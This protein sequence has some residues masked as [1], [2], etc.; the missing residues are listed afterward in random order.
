MTIAANVSV[1]IPI[2]G[3]RREAAF[4]H[5]RIGGSERQVMADFVDLAEYF[6][7]RFFRR[8]SIRR[9][10]TSIFLVSVIQGVIQSDLG[11]TTVPPAQV[12]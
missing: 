5:R 2:G 6:E 9:R 1:G 3:G 12:L 8:K 4:Q 7:G 11:V 10:I